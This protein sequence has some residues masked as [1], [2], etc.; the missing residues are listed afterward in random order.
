MVDISGAYA[1]PRADLGEALVE[2]RRENGGNWIGTKLFPTIDVTKK[3]ATFSAFTRASLLA[4][5]DTKRAARGRY[6][7][8]EAGAK[9][10]S[11]QTQNYGLEGA[12][13][14]SEREL[15]SSDFS[16]DLAIM[17]VTERGVK[18]AQEQR[19][20]ALAFNQ[21]TSFTGAT[22][23]DNSVADPWT[24]IAADIYGQVVD[25]KEASRRRTGMMP[26]SL[27]ISRVTWNRMKKNTA[28]QAKF[29]FPN[30][31]GGKAGGILTDGILEENLREVLGLKNIWIGDEVFNAAPE[32]S[33][34]N[35]QDVWADTHALLAYVCPQGATMQEPCL[36]RTFVWTPYAGELEVES[37]REEQIESDIVRVK[38]FVQEV[39]YDN[40][41][42]QLIRIKP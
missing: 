36:G 2:Y 6:N 24:N 20:A 21:T 41:Y 9:D 31:M 22:F 1:T 16:A 38:N 8:V 39:L 26:N 40:A 35:V 23:T 32:G 42:G 17:L 13:D 33:A 14:D 7:R 34:E 19:A 18:V 25:G 12:V 30:A 10:K 37:Y 3:A 27:V 4:T 5:A 15:Y 11:Y 29:K 28:L